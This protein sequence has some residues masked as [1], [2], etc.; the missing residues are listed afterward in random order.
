M[1]QNEMFFWNSLSFSVIQ[2]ML[3]TWSAISLPFLN[4]I[5]YLKVLWSCSVEAQLGKFWALL[6]YHE[7]WVKLCSSLNILWHFFSLGL[8]WKLTF[9]SPVATAE[10]S[11][12][13]GILSVALSQ[14]CLLG[15]EIYQ[16]DF[17]H[18]H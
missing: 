10:F 9:S 13:A 6:C 7:R 16:L 11:E 1:K 3:A 12:F 17:H 15:F 14:H 4:S 2:L 8:E 5:E 18:L